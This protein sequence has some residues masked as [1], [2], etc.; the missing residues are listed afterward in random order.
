MESLMEMNNTNNLS[1]LDFKKTTGNLNEFCEFLHKNYKKSGLL[2][3]I[4]QS[5]IFHSKIK[6]K[7]KDYKY[8]LTNL[9]MSIC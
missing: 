1:L 5:Q 7:K 2:S 8:I 3:N 4:H 9:R 6:R